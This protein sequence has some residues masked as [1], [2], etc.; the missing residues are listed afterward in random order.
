MNP[1]RFF[2]LAVLVL[3]GYLLY[4]LSPVLTP[5]LLAAI[6]A[7]IGDPLADRLEALKFPRFW[8]V[9]TV[10]ASLIAGLALII[11]VLIPTINSQIREIIARMPDYLRWFQVHIAPALPNLLN[12]DS[13]TPDI[14]SLQKTLHD[15]IGSV[16][17]IANRLIG[18][19]KGP[20][21]LII[22]LITYTFLIPVVTFYLLRDWDVMRAKIQ[23]LIP[24]KYRATIEELARRSDTVLGGFLRGQ[25]LVMSGLG[26]IY[27]IGL[28]IVGLEAAIMIG[29]FAGFVSFVPYL[30]LI[31]G[32]V[33]AGMMSLI[34]FQDWLHPLGVVLVFLF[35]Q[36]I[37]GIILT[38]KLV[39]DRT[40]LHPVAVLF[41]VLA[42]G[43]LFGF[44]GILLALPAAAVINV[45]L[46][47]CK[48]HY[49]N[50]ALYSEP[51]DDNDKNP[52]N[53]DTDHEQKTSE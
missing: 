6:L 12:I 39:G 26:I 11:L 40:G 23:E 44:M 33:V 21:G 1:S 31:V 25:L 9:V 15:H 30:G 37:E 35:A 13:D 53:L 14:A 50:S 10:F 24:C 4:L 20:A 36:L 5:F 41:A 46:G 34:Q 38:P 51:S 22:T 52:K 45:F 43:Q 16:S 19:L 32:I 27:A 42:G 17:H 28:G 47:Y 49:L 48:E 8:A 3:S 7:Y 18:S 29:L 2:W